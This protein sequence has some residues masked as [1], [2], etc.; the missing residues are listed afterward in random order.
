MAPGQPLET[1]LRSLVNVEQPELEVQDRFTRDAEAK[2]SRLDDAG[3]NRSDGYLE[4]SLAGHRP[5]W[6]ECSGDARHDAIAGKV[7]AE[8]PG[9]IRPI[10]VKRDTSRIWM[11]LGDDA[12]EILDL[13]FEP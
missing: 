7:L 2:M 11:A 10:V 3:V 6:M 12:E 4:H 8:R 9:A 1:L 13:T 5:E